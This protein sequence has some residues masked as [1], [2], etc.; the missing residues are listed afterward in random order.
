M[1][2]S[3]IYRTVG[4]TV[5]AVGLMA[6]HNFAEERS[7]FQQAEHADRNNMVQSSTPT[8]LNLVDTGERGKEILLLSYFVPEADS[9]TGQAVN[10]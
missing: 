7:G 2:L 3:R 9:A 5:A 10:R 4:L 8:A 1:Q 6:V